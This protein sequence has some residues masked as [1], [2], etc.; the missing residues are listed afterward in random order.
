M[1]HIGRLISLIFN[2]FSNFVISIHMFV[3]IFSFIAADA[4]RCLHEI[5][6]T[7]VLLPCGSDDDMCATAVLQGIKQTCCFKS[8]N[9]VSDEIP[10]VLVCVCVF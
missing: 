5:N 4:L 8:V 2:L 9:F 6:N 1:S 10:A 7:L 3:F